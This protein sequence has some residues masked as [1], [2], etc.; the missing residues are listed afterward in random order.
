MSVPIAGE[1]ALTVGP[2]LSLFKPRLADGPIPSTFV[3]LQYDI[4]RD[5]LLLLNLLVGKDDTPTIVV[6]QNWTAALKK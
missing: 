6:Y 3:Q 2:P 1:T 5:G 4:A